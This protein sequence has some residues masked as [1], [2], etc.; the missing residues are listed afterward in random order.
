MV[1][2][3][4]ALADAGYID[5]Q[6]AAIEFRYAEG[7]YDRLPELA[8]DLTRRQVAVIVAAPNV[9]AARAAKAV[10]GAIPVVFLVSDDPAKLGLVA[11][12]NRPGGNATGVNF[13]IS[14]LVGK[15]LG[16]LR[17]LLPAA[18]RFGALINP[19][20]AATDAFLKDLN[21]AAS[22]LRVR[23]D[24]AHAR[25]SHE[26]EAAFATFARSKVDGLTLAPDTLF[27]NRRVQ[28]VTLAAR[29]AIPAI[30]T[31]RSYVDNGG[32]M[33]YGPNQANSYRQLATYTG[34]ILRGEKP[35]DLP[36]VQSSKFDLVINLPTARALDL[37]IPPTLL[38]RADEV[39]E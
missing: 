34:R 20:A 39:I 2:F 6:N 12:L 36:V 13:V 7:Q 11:S 35:A 19:N 32:L 1:A 22:T 8:A 16:L 21:E 3:R 37:Q 14:E 26:I 30:Y 33:S 9:N 4:Q 27:A 15:R 23:L 31:V 18:T 24:I 25:D 28:I 17:E 29:H 10:A 38:A 5:R